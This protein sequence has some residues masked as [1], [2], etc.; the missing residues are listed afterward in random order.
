MNSSTQPVSRLF[1]G[2]P[3]VWHAMRLVELPE[4]H[5]SFQESVPRGSGHLSNGGIL[6]STDALRAPKLLVMTRNLS[7]EAMWL[8]TS[9]RMAFG[10]DF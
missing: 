1:Q 9:P 6:D 2:P 10:H 4:S 7:K 5:T 3:A 8:T